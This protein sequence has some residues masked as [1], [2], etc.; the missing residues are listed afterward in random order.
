MMSLRTAC[1]LAAIAFLAVVVWTWQATRPARPDGKTQIVVWN[2][3]LM[4]SEI[5]LALH[6]FELENPQYRVVHSSSVAPNTTADGQRLLT[7]VAGGVPPDLMVFDR[8]AIAEWAAR[9]ALTD[10]GPLLE[11]QDPNDPNRIDLAAFYPWTIEEGSYRKPGTNGPARVYGIPVTVDCRL[12]FS[13][14]DHLRQAGMVDAVTG[15]PR[16]PKTWEELREA[17]N[18]LTQKNPV[19]GAIARLGFAPNY[20]NSWLYMYAWQAGGNLLSEDGAK[21]LLDSPPVRRAL[22]FI[23]DVYDDLGGAARVNAFQS[24]FQGGRLDPFLTGQVSMK[25]DSTWALQQMINWNPRMDFICSP[26]PIPG[27][28]L[29]AGAKPITWAGGFSLI[30]PANS[31]QTEGAFKLMQFL[32]SRTMYRFI[33]QANRESMAAEGRLYLPEPHPNRKLFEEIEQE[34]VTGDPTVPPR[35]KQAYGVIK[36]MLPTARVRPP[37]PI[38]QV[39]WTQHVRA[40]DAAINHKYAGISKDKDEEVQHALATMGAEAQAQLDTFLQPLPPHEVKWAGFFWAYAGLIGLAGVAMVVAYRRNRKAYGYQKGEVGA[41]LLFVSPWLLGMVLL[42]GGPILFSVVTSFTRYDVL[43]PARYVG[44]ENYQR[45]VSDEVFY[46]SLANTGFM[47]LRLP[48]VM[49][50][51][52]LIAMLLNRSIRGIGFYRTAFFLPSIVPIVAVSLLWVLLLNPSYGVINT[53]LAWVFNLPPATWV[54]ALI[55]WGSGTAFEFSPPSWL[56]DPAWSKPSLILMSLWGAGGGMIIWLAGLQSIPR[57]L[58]EAA[59]IDGAGAWGRFRHVTLPMLSPYILFNAVIGVIATMQIFAEA[60]IMTTGGPADSTLFY[61]YYLFRNAF[62]YFRMGYAS[63]LAWILFVIVL[64]LTLFQ[65]W[66]SRKWV[67]YDRT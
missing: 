47:V 53:V 60:Y 4:G 40:M 2:L 6:E 38:G 59:E 28:R 8:F 56:Q 24:S 11:R 32:T 30:I 20:G 12:L 27:D 57:Q 52:L 48:L 45:V 26:A 35:V 64:A 46:T 13:N 62:Q 67:H 41:A 1:V 19:N 17:A 7:A 14:S 36:E 15:E 50:V 33:Q 18:T 55:S 22:R 31:Q 65:M 5:G 23:V 16:P 49:A 9:N 43:S 61:A 3:G 54:E 10:L 51:G 37:S 25:I 34:W 29:A 58:Y 21:V 66:A 42:T 63:A 44:L 39:L